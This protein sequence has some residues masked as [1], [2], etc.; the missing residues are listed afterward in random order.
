MAISTM[1][2]LVA[3][4]ATG[5][6]L[7]MQKA[8]IT[9][10][11]SFYYSLWAAAGMPGKGSLAIGNTANGVVPTDATVGAPLINAFSG[12][13]LGY[14]GT[15]DA[16]TAQAGVISVYDR[17]FHAGSYSCSALA[18]TTLT[19]QPSFAS[20]VPNSDYSGI[21]MWLEVNAAS[22]A[23]ATTVTVSYTNQDGTSGR[24]ATLDSNLSSIPA[25]RMLPFRL[26]A[27]DT[28]VQRV[29]S[30]T[31][32]G[33]TGTCTFNIVLMRN[34]VDH[35]VVSANIGR[36]KKNPFDTGMPRVF[37]D[38]CLALMFCATTTSSGVLFAEGLIING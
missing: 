31:V 25:N 32:G 11:A 9:T 20:R 28:G 37:A 35:T 18:T 26:A 33:A 22:G 5:Q 15:W 4:V 14:V 13:N 1:D 27:G 30:V 3:A 36:P 23:T 12:A 2:G 21:E 17:L 6:R 24:T 19:A 16:S 7:V 38:S 8:S 29:D 10:V 34:L